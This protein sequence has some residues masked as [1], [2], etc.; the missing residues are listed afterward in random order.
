M[1]ADVRHCHGA[2]RLPA[3]IPSTVDAVLIDAQPGSGKRASLHTDDPFGVRNKGALVP[4]A[5]AYAGLI[6]AEIRAVDR[7][8]RAH[9]LETH[10]PVRTVMLELVFEFA[11]EGL[12]RSPCHRSGI[13]V[14]FPRIAR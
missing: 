9:A 5:T 11:F 13:A 1:A 4:I 10:G 7:F 12:Q 8:V 3:V 2:W 6:D 14:R